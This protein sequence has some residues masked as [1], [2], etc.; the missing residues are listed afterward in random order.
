LA[1]DH[2]ES[3]KHAYAAS[4]LLSQRNG[5]TTFDLFLLATRAGLRARHIADSLGACA[6][7]FAGLALHDWV[8]VDPK[9]SPSKAPAADLLRC[10]GAHLA[11]GEGMA[12]TAPWSID[13]AVRAA[14]SGSRFRT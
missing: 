6:E 4:K 7:R 2:P 11:D 1:A 10:V 14:P 5:W 13:A 8:A 12:L 9:V 3:V